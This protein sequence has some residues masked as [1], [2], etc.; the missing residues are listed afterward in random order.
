MILP[1]AVDSA[2]AGDLQRPAFSPDRQSDE[3]I[4]SE[5]AARTLEY[6]ATL[7]PRSATTPLRAIVKAMKS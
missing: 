4:A 6:A 7:G 2:Y 1:A 5:W 3:V